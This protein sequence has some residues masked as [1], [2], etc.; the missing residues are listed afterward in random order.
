MNSL[1]Y[2]S[3]TDRLVTK[4][5]EIHGMMAAV[6]SLMNVIELQEMMVLLLVVLL[7][8]ARMLS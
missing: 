7:P 8:M 5:F 2:F 3:T 6:V 4:A 1:A